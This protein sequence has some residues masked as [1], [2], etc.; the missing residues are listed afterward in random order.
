MEKRYDG[1][2]MGGDGLDMIRRKRYDREIKIY[3]RVMEDRGWSKGQ[4]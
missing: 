2:M 4:E 1:K 3:E